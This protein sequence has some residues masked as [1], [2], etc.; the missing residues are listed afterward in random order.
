RPPSP[1]RTVRETYASYGSSSREPGPLTVPGDSL[2]LPSTS[3]KPLVTGRV[4]HLQVGQCVRTTEYP[5]DD[6][7]DMPPGLLG[8]HPL[9]LRALASL[10]IPKPVKPA[11][12]L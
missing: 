10:S 8:D 4:E 7:V 1:L 6:M 12:S 11:T 2:R 9:A 5:P 3:V